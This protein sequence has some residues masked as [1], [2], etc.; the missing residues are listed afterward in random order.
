MIGSL[1]YVFLSST[2]IFDTSDNYFKIYYN[3]M[4]KLFFDELLSVAFTF[5]NAPLR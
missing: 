3:Y 1:N 5:F 2:L 4:I